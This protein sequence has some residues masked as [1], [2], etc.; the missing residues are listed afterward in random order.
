MRGEYEKLDKL[1]A[2]PSSRYG[3]GKNLEISTRASS[4]GQALGSKA[5]TPEQ[6]IRGNIKNS[7]PRLMSAISSASGM[8][9]K[10]MDSI[11]EMQL[12]KESVSDPKQ[13]IE[14]VLKT[15]DDLENLYGVGGADSVTKI[16]VPN[17]GG[18][19][20]LGFE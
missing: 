4:A 20:F 18:I 2:I 14:T 9:A 15:L 16:E 13:P 17:A 11:P 5:A 7:I 3:A 19:K 10:Q 8:S 1:Q 6:V 12:L